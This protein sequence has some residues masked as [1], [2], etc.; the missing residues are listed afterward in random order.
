MRQQQGEWVASKHRTPGLNAVS[1]REALFPVGLAQF[2]EIRI[3][4][5]FHDVVALLVDA[6]R[7]GYFRVGDRLP[8]ERE[9]ALELKVSRPVVRDALDVL[10]RAGICEVRRGRFGGTTLVSLSGIPEVLSDMYGDQ[11]APLSQY[12]DVR[13]LLV[14]EACLRAADRATAEDLAALHEILDEAESAFDDFEAFLEHTVR[15]HMHVAIIAHN[16]ILTELLRLI[17]NPMAVI[18]QRTSIRPPLDFLRKAHSTLQALAVAIEE[19]DQPAIFR[20][21]DEH[22]ARVRDVFAPNEQS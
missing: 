6:I 21:V 2:G 7:S 9:L 18:G 4:P 11:L 13:R 15:Y 22:L 14:T 12:L 19:K 17:V 8:S 16:P 5:A 3:R 20:L 1:D 10:E